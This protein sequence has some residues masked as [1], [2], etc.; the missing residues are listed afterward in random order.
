[1][2]KKGD[3]VCVRVKDEFGYVWVTAVVD[4]LNKSGKLAHIRTQPS[5][6]ALLLTC[7]ELTRVKTVW[8]GTRDLVKGEND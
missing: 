3:A 4:R 7:E 1:M 5:N 6:V 8:S 2:F